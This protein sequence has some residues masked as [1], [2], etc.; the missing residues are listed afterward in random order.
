MARSPNAY[1][2]IAQ[3]ERVRP[4]RDLVLAQMLRYRF[5]DEAEYRREVAEP[6]HGVRWPQEPRASRQFRMTKSAL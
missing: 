4:R 5:I 3:P 2:L 6:L 1:S